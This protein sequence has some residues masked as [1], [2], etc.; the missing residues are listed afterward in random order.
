MHNKL[1]GSLVFLIVI[2]STNN[3]FA[4][5]IKIGVV[6]IALLLEQAPQ[7]RAASQALEKEFAPQQAALTKL[8][9]TMDKKQKDYQRNKLVMSET[10]RL[11]TEREI[12]MLNRD[13][14]RKRNDIQELVNIR[15]NEKLVNLQ[16]I[17]NAGIRKLGEEENFDLILYE[18]IAY[19]NKRIDVTQQV[20]GF[21]ND[22]YK[23]QRTSFN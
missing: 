3:I 2:F 5:D 19:T 7:A 13:I 9:K 8:A 1:I 23:Q 20:L 18:G 21:L 15:R 4:Q 6:N 14:Q 11:T 12:S 22:Q 16:N 10:Q 17:V